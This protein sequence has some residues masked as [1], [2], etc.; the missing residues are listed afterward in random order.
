MITG[1]SSSWGSGSAS[2]EIDR[3]PIPADNGPLVR[4][5]N[6]MF[7]EF[8]TPGHY[9]NPEVIIGE[10]VYWD[11]DDTGLC[12]GYLEPLATVRE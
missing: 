12:L 2:I 8:I 11:Y 6:G 4:A 7:P 5:L 10:E 1:W 9:V 3:I